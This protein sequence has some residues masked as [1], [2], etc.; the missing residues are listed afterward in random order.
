MFFINV[1]KV[2]ILYILNSLDFKIVCDLIFDS[3]SKLMFGYSLTACL[4]YVWTEVLLDYI[5]ST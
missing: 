1:F 2:I 4:F 5:L 3:L